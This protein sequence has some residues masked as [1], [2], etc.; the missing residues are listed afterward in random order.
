MLS[1]IALWV[2][3][4]P[5]LKALDFEC[6][7]SEIDYLIPVVVVNAL[8]ARSLPRSNSASHYI[9]S[10]ILWLVFWLC[11]YLISLLTINLTI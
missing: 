10:H 8:F 6:S 4:A 1:E 11:I 3:Q 7:V 2:L 5:N 9:V